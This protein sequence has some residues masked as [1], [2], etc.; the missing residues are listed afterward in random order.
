M[1]ALYSLKKL[2]IQLGVG[3]RQTS[4]KAVMRMPERSLQ[5]SG[6]NILHFKLKMFLCCVAFFFLILSSGNCHKIFAALCLSVRLWF[7]MAQI[8]KG[9]RVLSVETTCW[10][11]FPLADLWRGRLLGWGLRLYWTSPLALTS[12]CLAECASWWLTKQ[13]V[14]T[15]CAAALVIKVRSS[16]ALR[17]CLT[18]CSCVQGCAVL[19]DRWTVYGVRSRLLSA[20]LV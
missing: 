4:R 11:R 3:R 18:V 16:C 7:W 13:K 14:A 10:L 1:C 2:E 6:E 9:W 19:Q 20:R 15:V 5:K 12:C 17:R 8:R